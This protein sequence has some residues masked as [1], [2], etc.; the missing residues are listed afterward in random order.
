MANNSVIYDL[1]NLNYLAWQ[2]VQTAI[3][4]HEQQSTADI[5]SSFSLA[6]GFS[7]HSELLVAFLNASLPRDEASKFIFSQSGI[8]FNVAEQSTHANAA[9]ALLEAKQNIQEFFITF[10]QGWSASDSKSKVVSSS[11]DGMMSQFLLILESIESGLGIEDTPSSDR[12]VPLVLQPIKR[13]LTITNEHDFLALIGLNVPTQ[14]FAEPI[15]QDF[16]T[17]TPTPS[18]SPRAVSPAPTT[19]YLHG[20][21]VAGHRFFSTER[22]A[23]PGSPPRDAAHFQAPSAFGFLEQA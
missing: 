10:A 15:V 21:F 12:G 11:D 3:V 20:S 6:V 7:E 17:R 18:P 5:E 16:F 4:L 14:S 2:Q 8:S 22:Y 1:F 13:K 23:P 9:A 19:P